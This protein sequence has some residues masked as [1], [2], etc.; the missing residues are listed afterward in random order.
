MAGQINIYLD[1]S[2]EGALLRCMHG[3]KTDHSDPSQTPTFFSFLTAMRQRGE[4]FGGLNIRG[5]DVT[6]PTGEYQSIISSSVV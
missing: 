2:A 6:G 4:Q 1:S 5:A 3:N